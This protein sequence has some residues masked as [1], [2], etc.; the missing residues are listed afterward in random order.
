[1]TNLN[2][3]LFLVFFSG[4]IACGFFWTLHKL[5][6][7]WHSDLFTMQLTALF[8][9]GQLDFYNSSFSHLSTLMTRKLS[10][11]DS[12]VA[13]I[14]RFL[15]FTNLNYMFFI[16][17]TINKQEEIN[18]LLFFRQTVYSN[19]IIHAIQ[20]SVFSGKTATTHD[21]NSPS[22]RFGCLDLYESMFSDPFSQ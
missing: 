13:Y 22:S 16:G 19:L 3:L 2:I 21:N 9:N 11:A 15:V 20:L 10:W 14:H 17:L 7:M 6:Y 5:L 4:N 12:L 18:R 8:S 1:M